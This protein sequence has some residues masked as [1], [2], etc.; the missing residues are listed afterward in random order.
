LV[1]RRFQ[2]GQKAVEEVRLILREELG[3]ER[4]GPD[5]GWFMQPNVGF[6]SLVARGALGLV[7][8]DTA[9]G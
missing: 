3:S 4:L 8:G 7:M 2:L 6:G 5:F 9:S 1:S